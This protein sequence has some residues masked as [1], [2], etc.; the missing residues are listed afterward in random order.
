M[1]SLFNPVTL[2]FALCANGLPPVNNDPYYGTR[3]SAQC[4]CVVDGQVFS[5]ALRYSFAE[6]GWVLADF[7]NGLSIGDYS[8]INAVGVTHWALWPTLTPLGGTA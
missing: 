8:E 7:A 5:K 6:N 3:Y 4:L 2:I 1:S